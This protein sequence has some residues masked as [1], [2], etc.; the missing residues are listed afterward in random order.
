[1]NVC[2]ICL[3][4]AVEKDISLLP[5]LLEE[6]TR[7]YSDIMLFCL[8]IQVQT[9]SKLTSKLCETCFLNILSFYKFKTLA[10][11]NDEYLRSLQEKEQ[12]T[13]V[14]VIDD[15]KKEQSDNFLDDDIQRDDDFKL[16]LDVKDENNLEE[17][18]SDDEL[19]SV[20]KQL[21]YENTI[22][23]TKENEHVSPN[24]MKKIKSKKVKKELEKPN[25]MCEEC[26]KTV[27]NLKEHM[28][29]HKP[30]LIRKRYKCKACDKMFSSCSSRLKHYKIKHL[31]IKKHCDECNK[32]V[33]NLTSHR[34]VVHKTALLPFECVPCGRRFISKSLR[35]QHTL[36][37]TKDRPHECDQC[38]KAFR[39]TIALTQHKRQVHDKEKT[40]LCQFCSKRFFKK[41]H[42]QI[43]IRSHSKER[44]YE[45]PDC[46]KFFS[47]T[48][49][50]K[51]HRLIHTDVK[52]FA[53]ELCDMTFCKPGYLRNHMICHTKEKRYSCKY[54]GLL[55]GRSDHRLR[56]ERTSHERHILPAA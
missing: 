25:Q 48:S 53:C 4:L 7:T 13:E 30:L 23:E 42:L 5:D 21:K 11:K 20:I 2:R 27:R 16:A 37:H 14:F 35:D 18:Q 40:H 26:G 32:D 6:D 44:P 49:I 38:D 47:T 39:S 55:F 8:G 34:M 17:L 33:V 54:C 9:E 45:C 19:L 22:G 1:M 3:T 28:F 50:L 56:H 51:N 46:G 24:K 15:I 29:Q 36:I 41:Y 10:L 43:H 31:G 52:M 12:K